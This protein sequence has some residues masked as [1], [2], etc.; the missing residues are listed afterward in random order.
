MKN[1]RTFS[2][3]L[4]VAGAVLAAPAVASADTF[5]I[6]AGANCPAG[7]QEINDLQRAM[8]VALTISGDDQIVLGDRGT[9][10]FGPFVYQPFSRTGGTHL[11]VKGVGGRPALTGPAAETVLA[12]KDA[13]LEGVDIVADFGEGQA[14]Q[15]QDSTMRGVN[16]LGP[17]FDAADTRGIRASGSVTIE[18]TLVKG[19]FEDS[20]SVFGG[21]GGPAVTARRLR[22]EGSPVAAGVFVAPFSVLRMSD[23]RVGGGTSAISSRGTVDIRRSVLETTKPDSIGVLQDAATGSLDLDHV[24]VAHRGAPSGADAAVQLNAD[25]NVDTRLHAVALAGYTRGFRRVTLN[26]FPNPLTVTESVWDPTRDEL[27]GPAAGAFVESGNAHVAPAVVDLAG[28]DLRPS[29]GSAL[30]DRDALSDISQYADLGGSPALDGDGDGVIRPDAGAFEFRLVAPTPAPPAGGSGGGESGPGPGPGP[31]ADVT[32]PVLN[33]LGLRSAGL[34]VAR[35][36]RLSL[37]RARKL[38][39]VF[40]ASEAATVRIVPRRVV[41]GLLAKPRGSIVREVA[42]KGGVGLGKSLRRLGV[43]R[44][45]HLRLF[46]TAIDAAGNRSAKRV[47]SLRLRK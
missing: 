2:L 34:P 26:G 43:L 45:G 23:S 15:I 41:G 32:A 10:Y 37:V 29:T 8:D 3:T 22:V 5:C 16:V 7:G 20:L 27:G 47:L 31:G 11:T 6:N 14:L 30:I 28:G 24:T 33:R 36:A 38:R 35:A 4:L 19:G 9:P 17:A 12:L 44:P 21:E 18:D 39:L 25:A 42:G 1:L 46:V 13:S 40:T